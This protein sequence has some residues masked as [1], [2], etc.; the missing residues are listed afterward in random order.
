MSLHIKELTGIGL[1]ETFTRNVD[2]KGKQLLNRNRKFLQAVTKYKVMKGEPS[3][4]SE[5]V[6][7]MVLLLLSYF[8][9]KEDQMFSYVED[10][11]L[12]GEVQMD[13]VQ[14]T[15][16]IVVC[17]VF[18]SINPEKGTNVEKTTTSRLPVNPR[19]LT[20]IQELSDHEWCDV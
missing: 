3:G 5:D 9:E 19:V 7:E 16:T 1:K 8:N 6:K 11:C 12:A 15:P 14:L 2:L 10:T 4:C 18:F 17:G 20:L 13:Q